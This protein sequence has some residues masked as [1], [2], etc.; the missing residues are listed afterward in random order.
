MA[1]LGLC[2]LRKRIRDGVSAVESAICLVFIGE[3]MKLLRIF[4][5]R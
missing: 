1:A 5:Y 3:L 4:A 2:G